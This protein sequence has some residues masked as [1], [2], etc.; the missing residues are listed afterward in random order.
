MQILLINNSIGLVLSTLAV[1][2]FWQPPTPA[3]WLA[4]A[5]VGVMMLSAQFCYV[6][7]LARAESS[8]VVPFSY[9]TLVVAALLDLAVFGIVPD[10][11]SLLGAATILAGAGLLAWREGVRARQAG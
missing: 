2:A 9:A 3:Q 4:L 7:A 1:I 6:S 5:G 8:L 10:A 11:V